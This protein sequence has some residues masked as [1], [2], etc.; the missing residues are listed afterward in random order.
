MSR[1]SGATG[2]GPPRPNRW[3]P[4]PIR[5]CTGEKFAPESLHLGGA[6]D[7]DEATAHLTRIP[8]ITSQFMSVTLTAP[9]TGT[10]VDVNTNMDGGMIEDPM[11]AVF[12][13][14]LTSCLDKSLKELDPLACRCCPS[15]TPRGACRGAVQD[16]SG[17]AGA[18]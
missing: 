2:C 10:L 6:G 8:Y 18:P 15:P 1:S 17:H 5:D 3:C 7:A 12:K 16:L 4:K 14:S 13:R 11:E 9:D